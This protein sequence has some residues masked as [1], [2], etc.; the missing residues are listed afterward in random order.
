M[1]LRRRATTL[2]DPPPRQKANVSVFSAAMKE[3]FLE[4]IRESFN[5]QL[6]PTLEPDPWDEA[7]KWIEQRQEARQ[8]WPWPWPER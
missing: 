6:I 8:E 4:P 3:R 1:R 7:V 5:R 2:P